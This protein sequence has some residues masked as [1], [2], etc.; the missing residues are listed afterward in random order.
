[1]TEQIYISRIASYCFNVGKNPD[2]LIKLKLEGLQ[3]LNSEKEFQAEDLLEKFLRQDKYLRKDK[4]GNTIEV[5]FTENSKNGLLAAVKSFYV[6]TRGRD[7][8][9]RTHLTG[10][11]KAKCKQKLLIKN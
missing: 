2:E 6:S 5:E 11:L 1:M 4:D 9:K 8:A 10:F 3:N 7:L